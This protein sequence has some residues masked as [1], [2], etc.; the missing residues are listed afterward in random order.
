MWIEL[1][2]PWEENLMT[3]YFE[4]HDNY[5]KIVNAAEDN[6]LKVVPLCVEVGARG[7]ING[8]WH[9]MRRALKLDKQMQASQKCSLRR[10]GEVQSLLVRMFASSRMVHYKTAGLRSGEIE[11]NGK[12][13]NQQFLLQIVKKLRRSG[14]GV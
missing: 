4:K 11:I 5:R 1:T 8:K 3:W 2:S 12:F 14:Q 13:S 7:Y 6:G 10:S 9:H